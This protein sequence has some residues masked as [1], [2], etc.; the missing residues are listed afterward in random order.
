MNKVCSVSTQVDANT[1]AIA[2]IPNPNG[3][4]D[5]S[6][7]ITYAPGFSNFTGY[8]K[9]VRSYN[10]G[11]ISIWARVGYTGAQAVNTPIMINIP[12]TF[13]ENILRPVLI[14]TSGTLSIG[15]VRISA[16]VMYVV[17]G[18]IASSTVWIEIDFNKL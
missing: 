2:S 7:D 1:A 8:V 13:G 6:S 3:F 11:A 9:E 15:Y 10:Y 5:I 14:D 17:S 12:N 4:V 16:G 18:F